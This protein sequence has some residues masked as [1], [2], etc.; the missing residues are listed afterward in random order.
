MFI[1]HTAVLWG[2]I[3]KLSDYLQVYYLQVIVYK[4]KKSFKGCRQP[5][6]LKQPSQ[7]KRFKKIL[8]LGGENGDWAGFISK[9]ERVW[10]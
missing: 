1:I 9:K 2:I 4:F 6:N 10:V 8:F 5:L 3:L 7:E